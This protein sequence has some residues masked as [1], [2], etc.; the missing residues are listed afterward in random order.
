MN[1]RKVMVVGIIV[2]IIF[3]LGLLGGNWS[4]TSAQFSV[5]TERPK[6]TQLPGDLAGQFPQVECIFGPLAPDKALDLF[7]MRFP[8]TTSTLRWGG[9]NNAVGSACQEATEIYCAVPVRYLP[10][11]GQLNYYRQGAE[12]RQYVK[13]KLDSTESCAPKD[14]Y[15]DLSG[16]ERYMY[17]NYNDRF[18]FYI[19]NPD[20]RTWEAC[21]KVTFDE[22][23]GNYGRIT[24]S[25]TKWG[26]F[27]L[28]WP[29]KE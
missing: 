8:E 9:A 4:Q 5:P 23:V 21:P 24:C 13:G 14:V 6:P 18:G 15:F 29:P 20:N 3:A 17:D 1:Q 7:I 2:F 16:Y 27:A 28:G 25:T 12:V 19:Y 26:F 11:R 22:K 10:Q